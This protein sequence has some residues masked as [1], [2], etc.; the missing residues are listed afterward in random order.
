MKAAAATAAG[1]AVHSATAQKF[2]Y[3]YS[4]TL[5]CLQ[6]NLKIKNLLKR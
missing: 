1:A 6:L 2:D 3:I 5:T 4:H